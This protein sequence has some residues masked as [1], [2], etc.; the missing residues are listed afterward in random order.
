MVVMS[1]LAEASASLPGAPSPAG[2]WVHNLHPVAL[3]LGFFQLRWY[4]LA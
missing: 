4:S 2:H 1:I 3:D